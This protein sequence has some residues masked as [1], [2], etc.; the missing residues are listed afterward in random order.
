MLFMAT[1]LLDILSEAAETSSVE[2]VWSVRA[3]EH[4]L[5]TLEDQ[6]LQA[7]DSITHAAVRAEFEGLFSALNP[8]ELFEARRLQLLDGAALDLTGIQTLQQHIQD[9]CFPLSTLLVAVWRALRKCAQSKPRAVPNQAILQAMKEE[10]ALLNEELR[11]DGGS[12]EDDD[13]LEP[14]PVV[15]AIRHKTVI[16]RVTSMLR[17]LGVA[18]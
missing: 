16:F 18:V 3:V 13:D 5:H 17:R 4:D 14:A 8:R 15:R 10:D 6:E 11:K 2:E 7:Q 12:E 9:E 1:A